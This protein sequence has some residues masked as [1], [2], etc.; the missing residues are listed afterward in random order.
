MPLYRRLLLRC[1][2]EARYPFSDGD[3]D[4]DFPVR[5][6]EIPAC[7]LCAA[8][9]SDK[10]F[11][12]PGPLIV[13]ETHRLHCPSHAFTL[14]ALSSTLRTP[15]AVHSPAPVGVGTALA[16]S[17]AAM[18]RRDTA[19]AVRTASMVGSNRKAA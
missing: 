3:A 8:L 18:S 10:H 4:R 19:P 6:G 13:A 1:G 11:R 9:D 17:P 14:A 7:F 5:F 12:S 2:R 16:T 15:V